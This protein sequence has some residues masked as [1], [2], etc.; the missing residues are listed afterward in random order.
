MSVLVEAGGGL[1]N[2]FIQEGLADTLIQFIA[3]KIL[4]DK[5]GMTF[6]QGCNRNNITDCNNLKILSTKK[7]KGD[8]IVKCKFL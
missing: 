7:L 6:A 8:I 3:P 4:A 5:D 1:N 2:S